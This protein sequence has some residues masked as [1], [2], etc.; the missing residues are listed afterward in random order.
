[1]NEEF[2]AFIESQLKTLQAQIEI[3]KGYLNE[4]E[5]KNRKLKKIMSEELIAALILRFEKNDERIRKLDEK[6]E[7]LHFDLR[8]KF[9]QDIRNIKNELSD[10]QLSKAI[11]KLLEEK[12]I[13]VDSKPLDVLKEN[14]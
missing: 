12:E 6:I 11:S 10:T 3:I 14:Y 8:E 9:T 5:E 4:Y 1:V 2:E 7:S 13:K